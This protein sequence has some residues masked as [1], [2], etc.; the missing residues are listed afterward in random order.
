MNWLAAMKS[1]P[2]TPAYVPGVM[3]SWTVIVG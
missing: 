3:L 1:D 2:D